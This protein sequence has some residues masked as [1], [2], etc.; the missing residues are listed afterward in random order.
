MCECRIGGSVWRHCSL[1]EGAATWWGCTHKGY[2]WNNRWYWWLPIT[3]CQGSHRFHA[4][5]AQGLRWG[6]A[7][8]QGGD[9]GDQPQRLQARLPG[10]DLNPFFHCKEGARDYVVHIINPH[11]SCCLGVLILQRRHRPTFLFHL[12]FR[13]SQVADVCHDPLSLLQQ[14]HFIYCCRE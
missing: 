8:A 5:S 11:P 2:H 9:S 10:L 3:W 12:F 6:Q 14:L 7:E 13:M 4:P 1:F